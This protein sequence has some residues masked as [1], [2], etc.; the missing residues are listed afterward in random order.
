MGG[1]IL[2]LLLTTFKI[3]VV[4]SVRDRLVFEITVTSLETTSIK[5]GKIPYLYF[6]V[7]DGP[8]EITPGYPS[9]P[10]YSI[11]FAMPPGKEPD[12]KVT[13][14]NSE[15]FRLPHPPL[16]VPKSKDD[17]LNQIYKPNQEIYSSRN[18]WPPRVMDDP[19]T[20]FVRHQYYGKIRVFPVSVNIRGKSGIFRKRIRIEVNFRGKGISAP[21]PPPNDP[22]EPI[23]KSLFINYEEGK[24]W[25]IESKISR[26]ELVNPFDQALFWLKVYIRDEGIYR[27]GYG[28]IIEAGIPDN[29]DITTYSIG[30]F[31]FG[32]DTL[33]GKV[34]SAFV[35][36]KPVSFKIEDDGDGIFNNNDALYFYGIP[37]KRYRWSGDDFRYFE[38]PYSDTNVYWIGIFTEEPGE[39]IKVRDVTPTGTAPLLETSLGTYRHEKN[40]VNIG[41]KGIRW[42]G[43]LIERPAGYGVRDTTFEIE[44]SNLSSSTG[45]LNVA[46]VGARDQPRTIKVYLN[47]TLIDTVYLYE[48]SSGYVSSEVSNLVDGIN[49]VRIEIKADSN[50]LTEGDWVYLDYIEIYYEKNLTYQEGIGK[51]FFRDNNGRYEVKFSGS[52]DGEIWDITDPLNPVELRGIVSQE[53][54]FSFEDTIFPGKV[55]LLSEGYLSPDR[56]ELKISPDLRELKDI[57][58]VAITRKFLVNVLSPLMDFYRD[59][60]YFW[61]D[62]DSSY[63]IQPAVTQIVTVEDIFEQFGYGVQDPVA[64]RNFIRY[65]YENSDRKPTYVA[66]YGDGH[67]DYKNFTGS[68]GNLIP[69]Y[70]PWEIID[71]N[72]DSHGAWDDFF[73]DIDGNGL[74][75]IFMGR[76]PVRNSSELTDFIVKLERYVRGENIGPWKYRI[77]L[78]A[79]DEKGGEN[80]FHE[81]NWHVKPSDELF[82]YFIPK[83]LEVQT[84]Y[85]TDIEPMSMRGSKGKEAFTEKFNEG[86][87][88][89]NVFSHGNPVQ[90]TH[91]KIFYLP[92][93]QDLIDAGAKNPFVIIASC[94]T[95]AYDRV[96]PTRVIAEDWTL[97]DGGA[98]AVLSTTTL[99]YA[100]SN[101]NYVKAMIRS[102][103][104]N[105]IVPLGP[106]SMMGKYLMILGRYYVLIGD[107]GTGFSFPFFKDTLAGPDTLRWGERAY[108]SG[109]GAESEKVNLRA[110][111]VTREKTYYSPY[112]DSI[113]YLLPQYYY[114]N[115]ILRTQNGNFSGSFFVPT[116]I[117]TGSGAK[118]SVFDPVPPFGGVF[119]RYPIY[120]LSSTFIPSDTAG[121]EIRLFYRGKEIK[122]TI[123]VPRNTEFMVEIADPYGINLTENLP[124]SGEKGIYS[125]VNYRDTI[126][127]R[128]LFEYYVNSDTSGAAYFPVIFDSKGINTM[129]IKAYDN[130]GNPSIWQGYFYIAPDEELKIENVMAYPN[131]IRDKEGTTFLFT[132]NKRAR[133]RVKIFTVAGRLIWKS[134]LYT[135]E[136]DGKIVWNGRDDDG[137][138]PANGLY[139][140]KVEAETLEGEKDKVVEKLMIAR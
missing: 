75:D 35:V 59:N 126:D 131:P 95:A 43:E 89:L 135:F 123:R 20:G 114:F 79:D 86:C 97:R 118:V 130:L 37:M 13:V 60:L 4:E 31:S 54:S 3:N 18:L 107:P 34:D 26:R 47:E 58:Y 1:I 68:T 121:P 51:A 94:K 100:G 5:V 117:D 64:I 29:L 53:L 113:T 27:I 87:L 2:T 45:I 69:P 106:L 137:D 105:G 49:S 6:D 62:A 33:P 127:L 116:L 112:G 111:L 92:L 63:V 21:P 40:L 48:V 120:I 57:D 10:S 61:N 136:D 76:I 72:E 28:D 17:G 139:F 23:Y 81:L 128:P 85:L 14:L 108:I 19:E 78:V 102:L 133:V 129:F 9:L 38:H 98:I 24:N 84:V 12:V 101:A 77:V 65:L 82:R 74:A 8:V 90:I 119:N 36:F 138:L 30:M 7:G 15:K 125:I 73:T 103:R 66:L 110:Y 88:L 83:H 22:F 25:R 122:D 104:D 67:F 80:S 32:G 39:T 115:G 132:V 99:S 41:R 124:I 44:L 70:E 42:E 56:I 55:Y 71:V 134:P 93:D 109:E 96:L 52:I 46:V 140:F 91:E 16:P 11:F 50:Y